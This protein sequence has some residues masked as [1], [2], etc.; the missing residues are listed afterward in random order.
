MLHELRRLPARDW[1]T[2][3]GWTTLGTVGCMIVALAYN[4]IAFENLGAAA[5]R[6]SITSSIILPLILAMPLFAMLSLKLIRLNRTNRQLGRDA[7][8]DSLTHVYNRGA[9]SRIVERQLNSAAGGTPVKGALL[10]ID[11]DNFKSIND[12]FGHHCG[13]EALTIIARSIRIV[14]RSG[15]I[16]GRLGGE[17]FCVFLPGADQE[18]ASAV[19]ERIRKVINFA[20]FSPAGQPHQLSVSVGGAAF[21]GVIGFGELFQIADRHLYRAKQFG[22]N[23]SEVASATVRP[24]RAQR[25]E[26]VSAA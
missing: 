8:M 26:A 20:V 18:A 3:T 1:F 24:S 12:R 5:L 21:L 19:A 7:S 9:F 4:R 10:V 22:R 11:A 14:V 17:E 23:R 2:L 13:D 6:Q 16:V 15:D 25:A